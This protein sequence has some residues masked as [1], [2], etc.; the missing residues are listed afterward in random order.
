MDISPGQLCLVRSILARRLPGCKV[1]AFGS[2]VSGTAKKHSDLDLALMTSAPLSVRRMSRLKEAFSESRLPFKVDVVDWSE[3][4]EPFRAVI[5]ARS[6]VVQGS[7]SD[8]T[9]KPR[10]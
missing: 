5:R 10:G 8:L 3:A 9:P 7:R 6:E 1:L 2:R 4:S